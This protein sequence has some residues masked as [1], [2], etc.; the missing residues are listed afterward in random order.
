MNFR[1]NISKATEAACLFLAHSNGEINVMKLV[2][3]TYLLDRLSLDKRGTPVCGGDYLSMRNGPV[4][5]EMIDLINSGRLIGEHDR[6]WEE[7]ISGRKNHEVKLE[8]MPVRGHLSDTEVGLLDEIW[9]GHGKKDQWQLVE[10]C[11]THC[12][13]WTSVTNGCAPIAVEQV[14]IALGK[15]PQEVIRLREEAIE[16]NQ[17]DEIFAA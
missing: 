16:L 4:T 14:G 13:E 2:K 6:R 7:C 3:L 12:K 11:H 1:F 5:S 8:K 17:L 10:W 15:S 9:A